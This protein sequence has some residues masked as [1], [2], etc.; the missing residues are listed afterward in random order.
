LDQ[1]EAA[2][3]AKPEVGGAKRKVTRCCHPV[4]VEG[5][6]KT[7]EAQDQPTPVEP[8]EQG[9]PGEPAGSAVILGNSEPGE[10]C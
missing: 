2:A 1:L 7:G 5:S 3:A 9:D 4:E 10:G 8:P 6:G